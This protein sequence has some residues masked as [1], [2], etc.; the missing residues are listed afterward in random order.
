M[1]ALYLI[2]SNH[3]YHSPRWSCKGK[4]REISG[5]IKSIKIWSD[6]CYAWDTKG[7]MKLLWSM[8]SGTFYTLRLKNY[9]KSSVPLPRTDD[10]WLQVHLWPLRPFLTCLFTPCSSASWP[11]T[12]WLLD[13]VIP[14]A[15]CPALQS[16]TPLV[17]TSVQ[18]RHHCQAECSPSSDAWNVKMD[19]GYPWHIS[20]VFGQMSNFRFYLLKGLE[21]IWGESDIYIW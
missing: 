5:S 21:I 7:S 13:G 12:G 10:V 19:V 17:S 9:P 8:K 11:D 6:G 18:R 1:K 15:A 2:N 20:M 14:A 16:T 4:E 3:H